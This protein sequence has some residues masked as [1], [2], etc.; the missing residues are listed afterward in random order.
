MGIGLYRVH[1][2]VLCC[3]FLNTKLLFIQHTVAYIGLIPILKPCS[4]PLL[5][6]MNPTGHATHCERLELH[7][8]QSTRPG[9]GE[10]RASEIFYNM[11]F[12]V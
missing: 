10:K 4:I 12:F 3:C 9:Q 7:T 2:Q 11:A 5:L 6:G 1:T 8:D